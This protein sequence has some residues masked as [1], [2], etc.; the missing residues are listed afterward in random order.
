MSFLSYF[1][2]RAL[3]TIQWQYLK[4]RNHWLT[5]WTILLFNIYTL[6]PF[7]CFCT[8]HHIFK[9]KNLVKIEKNSWEIGDKK[10]SNNS[11]K[12]NCQFIF[13]FAPSNVAIIA[14]RDGL[15]WCTRRKENF[16]KNCSNLLSAFL[17]R[18]AQN[19]KSKA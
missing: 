13:S 2:F 15:Q 10:P 19:Q 7:P 5:F 6:L 9:D 17:A 12:S 4:K 1:W 3:D 18:K 16:V 11:N 8:S 14:E